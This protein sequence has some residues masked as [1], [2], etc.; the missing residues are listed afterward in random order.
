[1]SQQPVH[2][3]SSEGTLPSAFIP[4]CAY[5]T[6]M[7]S[8]G[9][10]IPEVEFFVCNNFKPTVLNGQICYSSDLKKSKKS[11]AGKKHSFLFILDKGRCCR[12]DANINTILRSKAKHK[13]QTLD[14]E[15]SSEQ[16]TATSARIYIHTL[17]RFSD[18]KPGSF[19][20]TA[21]KKMTT[22]KSFMNFPETVRKCQ[23]ETYEECQT[24]NFL[25]S[26]VKQCGC[27]PWTLSTVEARSPEVI[28]Y[29]R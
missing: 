19:A 25:D 21:L 27:L 13:I 22:T 24:R 10:E 3:K 4:V 5:Q 14:L 15:K 8:L 28:I 18:F 7:G 20:I 17:G 23:V 9:E 11:K 29:W 2:L 26:V 16:Q 6:Q 12:D 1:M